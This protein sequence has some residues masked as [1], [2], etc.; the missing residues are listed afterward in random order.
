MAGYDGEIRIKT[1]LD[2]SEVAELEAY[3][4]AVEK[5]ADAAG[6]ELEQVKPDSKTAEP[7]EQTA[8]ALDHL[9][10]KTHA[11]AAAGDKMG[12]AAKRMAERLG[13]ARDAA[14]DAGR[15]NDLFRDTKIHMADG[16]TFDWD[17][18]VIEEAVRDT[19]RLDQAQS[20]L[21][22]AADRAA[23]S[24]RDLAEETRQ[25]NREA[26]GMGEM[27]AEGVEQS[28]M[29][30]QNMLAF[31]RQSFQDIPV[32]FGGIADKITAKTR[33]METEWDNLSDKAAHYKGVLQELESRGLGFGSGEYDEAYMEWQKAEQAV[34]D[35][36]AQLAGA[37][38]KQVNLLAGLKRIGSSVNGIFRKM[39][40]TVKRFFS[41][42]QTGAKKTGGV[43]GVMAA[44][45]RGL[46][47]SLLVFNW[48]SKGFNAMVAG[49]RKGFE[50]LV[51]YSDSYANSVQT[52]KNAQATLGNSFAAAFAPIIQTVIP[53]LVELIN[54]VN[55][56]VNA[57]GQLFAYLSGKSTWTKATQVQNGY[58]DAL[59][60]TAGAAKKALG[61]LAKFDDLDVLQK[62]EESSGGGG[63]GAA[64]GGFEEVP[65]DSDIKKFGD[66]LK[67][68]LSKL[69]NPFK[70]AWEREGQFVMD[71]WKYALDE[72]W[73]LMKDIGRDFLTMWNQ[74]A[75]I[76][77]F[78][79]ILHIV[80]DIGLIVG[81]LARNFREA[82]N[83]NNA[84]LRIL[85]N[86]RDIFA[87]II[88]NIRLA[89]DATV[90]WSK[91]IDFSP[92][93][94]ALEKWTRS[95]IP[96][97]KQVSGI[98]KDFYEKVLL[99]ISKWALE[100]GLPDL[101]QV[102]I[103]FNNEVNWS[104]IRQ[105]LSDFWDRLE[106]FAEVVG[107]GLILFIDR[108]ADGIAGLLNS[109]WV[110]DLL[111]K[112]GD[113][114][115]GI[116]AE[117]VAN[118]LEKLVEAFVAFKLVMAG[119]EAASAIASVI[120][121]LK[122]LGEAFSFIGDALRLS[123]ITF[124]IKSVAEGAASLGE[125]FEYAFPWVKKLGGLLASHPYFTA[126]AGMSALVLAADK[127]AESV[128]NQK[129]IEL[130]GDTVENLAKQ[131]D[132][133]AEAIGR[134]IEASEDYVSSAG[135]AETE[136]AKDLADQYFNLAD[137]TNKTAAEKEL[138]KRYA[139]D[140]VDLIPDLNGCID[141]ETGYLTV[142]R[143]A[144]SDLITE[145]EKYY[146]VQAAREK[147]LQAYESQL[148][149]EEALATASKEA[150]AAEEV[151][152]QSR[153][154]YQEIQKKIA[155]GEKGWI[156]ELK[157]SSA[158]MGINKD[159]WQT[160][161]G[162]LEIAQEAFDRT[163]EHISF[164]NEII[165]ESGD[166]INSSFQM[167]S[168]IANTTYT[169]DELG[170]IWE[171]GRLLL[172][173]KAEEIRQEIEGKLLPDEETVYTL[174]NGMTISYINGLDAGRS[175]LSTEVD[176]IF[177]KPVNQIL[178]ELNKSTYEKG[179]NT[180]HG[181]NQGI[182]TNADATSSEVANWALKSQEKIR[183]SWDMHSPSKVTEQY[184][185]YVVDG[186]NIGIGNN[187][188]TTGGFIALWME[189]TIGHI[190]TGIEE[191]KSSVPETLFA[192]ILSGMMP[193]F[194]EKLQEMFDWVNESAL[195][196]WW[197]ECIE[198]W[199]SAGK[200]TEV[201]TGIT[202]AVMQTVED[203]KTYWNMEIPAWMEQSRQIQFSKPKWMYQFNG[204]LEALKQTVKDWVTHWN[205]EIP[206]WMEESKENQFTKEK[207]MYQFSGILDALKQTI[208]DWKDFWNREIVR[209]MKESKEQQFSKSKWIENLFGMQ[210][211]FEYTFENIKSY[212]D[213]CFL[214]IRRACESLIS[215]VDELISKLEHLAEMQVS[216]GGSGSGSSSSGSRSRSAMPTAA[217]YSLDSLRSIPHLASGSVIRGGN[218]FLAVLGDQR[219]GQTNVE[220]PLSTIRQAVRDELSGLNFGG[221]Q[222]KVVL[223][224]NGADLAQATLQDFLSEMN[225]QG[226]DVEVLGVT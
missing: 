210:E 193:S 76:S 209:W 36:K 4:A 225:R 226:L 67:D 218:P 135:L 132:E 157:K 58:N 7:V 194:Q 115:S 18:N 160:L 94:Q 78:A 139:S 107:E 163:K 23:E 190:A 168:V 206:K 74:E 216:V 112:I 45:M 214:A 90:V 1:K 177:K 150:S 199:F 2:N 99:K 85:E 213:D 64:D 174:A 86:I 183:N 165:Y 195:P 125:G 42:T 158:Q 171:N 15:M 136:M 10:Q 82:W 57:L 224:V 152:N 61:A 79:D 191:I 77:M 29:P 105:N 32:L 102:F 145:T 89:A 129:E 104:A 17:G 68:I 186:F 167:D 134:H 196:V 84:G 92:L 19:A 179:A 108:L 110:A 123:D 80:G 14:V 153:E 12:Q 122:K 142:Q 103:D 169:I 56:A 187:K 22:D 184:G 189:E 154:Y 128:Q 185:K 6:K 46:A 148:D 71:S 55:R 180:V 53:Y 70:E 212:A 144:V 124:A 176:N 34:R 120:L 38:K 83:E 98:L 173:G 204:I 8:A 88:R 43:M 172:G 211:G 95:L 126:A 11:A 50:S 198:V 113:A 39:S 127:Y 25:V 62:K 140:L 215:Q 114:I 137:K 66:K 170:N 47:L 217:S 222:L 131:T 121:S 175:N 200:W 9:T 63:G 87:V 219:A 97:A 69:F 5:K 27:P 208:E 91:K 146:R 223:E 133:A 3:L 24:M 31:I 138:L 52:L 119:F 37:R 205:I 72:V 182:S 60:G 143:D 220:A 151:Y 188:D 147:L 201:L 100:K 20:K 118:A 28:L 16:T 48:I 192:D 101:L 155:D 59:N 207:W 162:E 13:Q 30:V 73:K 21:S 130:Y 41:S 93:L 44:R 111:E 197:S 54:W 35:Y 116:E 156:D 202:E 49:M 159:N 40:A 26:Q 51:K 221:G 178:D 164:L 81:N 203:W 109:E 181:F 141:A 65:I 33:R 166:A 96:V 161:S 75:T 106:P 149:A 117:D